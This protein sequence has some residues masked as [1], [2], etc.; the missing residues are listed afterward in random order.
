MLDLVKVR[1]IITK[2]VKEGEAV[3]SPVGR[4]V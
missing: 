3:L 4:A 1:H 2:D